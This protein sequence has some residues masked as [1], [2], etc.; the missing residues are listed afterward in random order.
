MDKLERAQIRLLLEHLGI[1]VRQKLQEQNKAMHAD[2]AAR[3]ILKSGST[4]KASLRI[5]EELATALVQKSFDAAAGVAQDID[6]FNMV[7]TDVTIFFRDIEVTV[8]KAVSFSSNG[9]SSASR[10]ADRLFLEL[11]QKILRLV[12]T[13]RFAFTRPAPSSLASRAPTSLSTLANSR[14]NKGGA[15]LAAHWDE[16]WAAIAVQLWEGD[17]KPT[18]QKDISDAM[19][20]WLDERE[21]DAG[22]TA[23]TDRARTLWQLLEARLRG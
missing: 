22:K 14:Q 20:A 8:K 2:H 3:G 13:Q 9:P 16:M 23:V 11:K 17:L 21:L 5:A 6:A 12:E 15:P 18:R 4:I 10:E 19:F 1:E 7:L